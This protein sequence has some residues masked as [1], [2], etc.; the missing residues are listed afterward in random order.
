[1]F[2]ARLRLL[3]RCKPPSAATPESETK[4][5]PA[6]LSSRIPARAAVEDKTLSSNFVQSL[7]VITKPQPLERRQ[8]VVKCWVGVRFESEGRE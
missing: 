8:L 5:Y 7:L 3:R 2:P 1:M 6:R 4:R